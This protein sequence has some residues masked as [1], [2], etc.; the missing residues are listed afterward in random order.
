MKPKINPAIHL[1]LAMAAFALSPAGRAQT[2]AVPATRVQAV[3]ATPLGMP[4]EVQAMLE[5]MAATNRVPVVAGTNAAKAGEP[6]DLATAIKTMKFERT[7][8]ALA[9]M[10][11]LFA[12]FGRRIDALYATFTDDE[13]AI[14]LRFMT[15][16]T[17]QQRQATARLLAMSPTNAG[18]PATDEPST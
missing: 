8:E 3:I 17:E 4:E 9:A 7:P 10:A 13:L 16:I 6:K 11:P 18:L 5:K 2:A 12:D 14:I 15:G 1:T